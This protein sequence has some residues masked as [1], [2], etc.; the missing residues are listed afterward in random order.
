ML[1]GRL[2]ASGTEHPSKLLYIA[3]YVEVV[4]MSRAVMVGYNQW[5]RNTASMETR[6]TETHEIGW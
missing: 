6:P 3:S 5:Q 4:G 1:A 2:E